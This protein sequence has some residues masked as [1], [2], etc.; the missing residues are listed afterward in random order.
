MNTVSIQLQTVVKV[1][2]LIQLTTSIQELLEIQ[3][4]IVF[5]VLKNITAPDVDLIIIFKNLFVSNVLQGIF[6]LQIKDVHQAVKMQ[7]I[8]FL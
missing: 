4:L 1:F 5:N 2:V 8:I 7:D 6:L 3:E